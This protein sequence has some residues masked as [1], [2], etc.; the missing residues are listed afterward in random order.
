MTSISDKVMKIVEQLELK[1]RWPILLTH[2]EFVIWKGIET[3]T[4]IKHILHRIKF[5]TCANP[6]DPGATKIAHR[7]NVQ[8]NPQTKSY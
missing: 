8:N 7:R 1:T 5:N 6:Y 4:E 3:D 2:P